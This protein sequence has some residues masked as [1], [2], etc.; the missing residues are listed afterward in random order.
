[1]SRITHMRDMT[2]FRDM[3][4]FR[5]MNMVMNMAVITA[6]FQKGSWLFSWFRDYIRVTCFR[7]PHECLMTVHD[8]HVPERFM[9]VF[10]IS[11]LLCKSQGRWLNSYLFTLKRHNLRWLIWG[12]GSIPIA[13]F[14]MVSTKSHRPRTYTGFKK[15]PQDLDPTQVFKI[16]R[17]TS[18]NVGVMSLVMLES[19]WM[20]QS[21]MALA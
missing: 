20:Y 19:C 8:C 10:V 5:D 3:T 21:V 15:N 18:L 11:W 4:C 9:T 14:L 17:W 2:W 1:M 7:V 6:M 13:S 12:G 16:Q